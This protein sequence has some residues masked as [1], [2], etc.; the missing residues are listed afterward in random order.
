MVAGA[1]EARDG[2]WGNRHA[3]R[4]GASFRRRRRRSIRWCPSGTAPLDRV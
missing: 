1:T 2:A 3:A 4:C